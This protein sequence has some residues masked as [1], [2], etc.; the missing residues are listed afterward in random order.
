MVHTSN[1]HPHFCPIRTLALCGGGQC[2]QI[3]GLLD[4]RF[5]LV[6]FHC[7][8]H[9]T[10]TQPVRLKVHIPKVEQN[11]RPPL[12]LVI[13]NWTP[14]NDHPPIAIC[15]P[16]TAILQLLSATSHGFTSGRLSVPDAGIRNPLIL[17]SLQSFICSNG[18][19]GC[20]RAWQFPLHLLVSDLAR[21]T[22][23]IFPLPH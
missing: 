6:P 12:P 19:L 21:P 20:L 4:R 1:V 18:T 16:P 8:F 3:L 14:S 23:L 13:G 9:C 7:T 22:Y 10:R 15:Y 2:C 17:L 5:V 11:K